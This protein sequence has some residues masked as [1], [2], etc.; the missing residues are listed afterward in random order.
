MALLKSETVTT[1]YF[2][3]TLDKFDSR[4]TDQNFVWQHLPSIV[5]TCLEKN[6]A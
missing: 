5:C 3:P 6:Y 2:L 4:H 1:H